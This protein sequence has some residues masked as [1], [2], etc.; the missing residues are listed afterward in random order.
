[1]CNSN[2]Q[3]NFENTKKHNISNDG[4]DS[5]LFAVDDKTNF[6][7]SNIPKDLDGNCTF[8]SSIFPGLE[9]QQAP[10]ILQQL[11]SVKKNWDLIQI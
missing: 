11:F 10:S 2:A 5:L 8:F 3:F 6:V 4:K 1:M 7:D 9:F